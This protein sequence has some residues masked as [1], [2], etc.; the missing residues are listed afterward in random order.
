MGEGKT[1][2]RERKE[3]TDREI[4]RRR[5]GGGGEGGGLSERYIGGKV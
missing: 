1:G 4:E 5:G 2:G 3:E